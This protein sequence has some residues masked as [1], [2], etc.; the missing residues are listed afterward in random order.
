MEP[1]YNC[2]RTTESRKKFY[3]IYKLKYIRVFGLALFCRS[4]TKA[5]YD[6]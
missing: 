3:F 5:P 4:Y 6:L 1:L 2:G